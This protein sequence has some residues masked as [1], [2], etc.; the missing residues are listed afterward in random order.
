MLSYLFSTKAIVMKE[1]A[2]VNKDDSECDDDDNID[3]AGYRDLPT[4]GVSAP[5]SP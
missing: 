1:R 5:H 4:V 3:T 2:K